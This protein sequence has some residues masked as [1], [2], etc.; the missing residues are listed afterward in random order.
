MY[1]IAGLIE[2]ALFYEE[3]LSTD[4]TGEP[5]FLGT[6][7]VAELVSVAKRTLAR[8]LVVIVSL[9]YGIVK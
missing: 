8:I 2:K 1:Y 7:L 3:F 9:G 4:T 6:V 5:S